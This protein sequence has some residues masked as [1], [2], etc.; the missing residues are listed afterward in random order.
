MI[1]PKLLPHALTAEDRRLAWERR[2]RHP[3]LPLDMF[4][5]RGFSAAC[6]QYRLAPLHPCPTAIEDAQAFIRHLRAN[7]STHAVDPSAIA[8]LGNSA[9]GHL[10]SMLGVTDAVVDG[11]SSRVN[12]VVDLCGISD[13]SEPDVNHFPI[14]MS[15]LEQFMGAPYRGSEEN[16]RAASPLQYVDAQACPF[17][18]GHGEADDVVPISQSEA[19]AGKLFANGVPVE[20]HRLPGEGHSFTYDGW[21]KVFELFV[22]FLNRTFAHVSA[23]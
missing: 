1:A 9:G 21:Y 22:D 20:F 3:M 23:Q 6:V 12:A 11:V 14:S 5:S 17:F 18:I 10:A 16:W 8:A 13:L 4:A 2:T 15:F 7:A 19:L